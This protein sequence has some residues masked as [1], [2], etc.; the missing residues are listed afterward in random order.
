MTRSRRSPTRVA[1]LS[2]AAL[3]SLLAGCAA[4]GRAPRGSFG[5][6]VPLSEVG[7]PE[8]RAV[9]ASAAGTVALTDAD[10]AP[11]DAFVQR[12]RWLLADEVDVIASRE[13]FVQTLMVASSIGRVRRE[14]VETPG[15]A[16]I[17]LTFVGEPHEVDVTTAPRVMIGTGLNVSAR[18]RIVIRFVKTTDPAVPVRLQ[19]TARGKASTG[20][21]ENVEHRAE[22][23][24]VGGV[25]RRTPEGYRFQEIRR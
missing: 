20:A 10:L 22:E 19:V 16:T 4:R 13:Y 7:V 6:G 8:R 24:V 5:D 1:V 3:A 15:G 9:P 23:I 12:R 2:L 25:L 11:V 21:G 18:R 17:T 14:E